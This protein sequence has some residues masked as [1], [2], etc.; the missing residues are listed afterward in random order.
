MRGFKIAH[1]TAIG[2]PMREAKAKVDEL[3]AARDALPKRVEVGELDNPPVRV[4]PARRH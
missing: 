1:G 3:Q 2:I 4:L